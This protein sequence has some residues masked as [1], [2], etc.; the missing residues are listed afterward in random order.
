MIGMGR[1]KNLWVRLPQG[2]WALFP[3]GFDGP[4]FHLSQA[5]REGYE[6]GRALAL[7]VGLA[8]LG[9][10][11]FRAV[12][13]PQS[14]WVLYGGFGL[15]LLGTL[16]VMGVQG[17]LGKA[18]LLSPELR[19]QAL[20]NLGQGPGGLPAS[21]SALIFWPKMIL[22]FGVLGYGAKTMADYGAPNAS[23][24]MIGLLGLGGLW[25]V[26]DWFRRRQP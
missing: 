21:E 24:I 1:P 18:R 4:A 15:L 10:I 14:P 26:W 9:L 22:W 3:R 19:A 5:E 25:A 11:I 16:L 23:F 8:G 20:A 13:F 17:G 2:D 7:L 12:L 6:R